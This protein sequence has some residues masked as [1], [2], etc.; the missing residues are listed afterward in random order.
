[1]A[2]KFARSWA[3]MKASAGVLRS[4]KSLLL[5]PLLSG[6]CSIVVAAS[7]LVPVMLALVGHHG[8]D[9]D[10]RRFA[11]GYYVMLFAFYLAQ[12]FVF[13]HGLRS[14]SRQ[15]RQIFIFARLA[16]TTWLVFYELSGNDA[17]SQ[18]AD[19]CRLRGRSPHPVLDV[20][21]RF[22]SGAG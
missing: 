20:R 6:L 13:M 7:F 4:D 9:L 1:M 10:G 8:G 17:R 21:R 22:L 19:S 2:G 5:F 11:P 16:K 12:Y 3:L 15:I 14:I 18:P